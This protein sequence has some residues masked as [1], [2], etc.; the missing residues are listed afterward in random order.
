MRPSFFAAMMDAG[1]TWTPLALG[2]KLKAWWAPPGGGNTTLNGSG[3]ASWT[4]EV[5][6]YGLAQATASKQPA[7]SA[8]GFSGAACATFD[9]VD[10]YLELGPVPAGIPTGSAASEIWASC[11]QDAL[12]ADTGARF[13]VGYGGGFAN[14][15]RLARLVTSGVNQFAISSNSGTAA[16][17]PGD[18]SGVHVVRGVFN[19][20]DQAEMDGV[21]GA[22]VSKTISTSTTLL[23]LG[24]ST[25]STAGPWKGAIRQVLITDALT[26]G[27]AAS[28]LAYLNGGF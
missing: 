9:G 22:L 3:I 27:E 18:F 2:S 4:D 26:S 1:P 14:Q 23:R 5:G 13:V 19:G 20:G 28:L 25:A 17:S 8:T 11:S 21:A 12:V 7:Y 10:D 16:V 15:R 24:L 6:G